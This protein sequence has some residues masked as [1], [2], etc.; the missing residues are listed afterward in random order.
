MDRRDQEFHRAD[1]GG[2]RNARNRKRRKD[3]RQRRDWKRC[4]SNASNTSKPL[5]KTVLRTLT[6][7]NPSRP[8]SPP[9]SRRPDAALTPPQTATGRG[10][11]SP[12]ARSS[13][14]L[15][16]MIGLAAV[17]A[18]VRRRSIWCG[19]AGRGKGG[20]APLDA[21]HHLVFRGN[22]GTGKTT[23]ARIVGRFTRKSG[24]LKSGDMVEAER[25]DLV[26][27]YIGQT[28][29]K[30]KEVIDKAM[31]GVLFIDEAYSLAPPSVAER[32]REGSD[33]DADQGDGGQ[34][35]PAGGDRGRATR[36]E[37][38]HFIDS[39]PGLK[40]RFK[41]YIDFEDY[42][43]EELFRIFLHIGV[44]DTGSGCRSMR[45]R[46]FANLMASLETGK[47]G[48]GNGRTV[49]NIFDEC[50]ARQAA[51]LGDER[52]QGRSHDVREGR[53]SEGRRNG[54]LLADQVKREAKGEQ[55]APGEDACHGHAGGARH[56]PGRPRRPVSSTSGRG[57]ERE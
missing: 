35:R 25:G 43:S 40:S 21:P 56:Q 7:A 48:F 13:A 31:D 49:R 20:N 32:F 30:T 9:R 42:N 46:D 18:E 27:E 57:R 29:P 26:A 24:V 3:I 10:E 33:S 28:A 14:E 52:Q 22:P 38:D 39:N 55:P 53:Y 11:G 44:S 41:T 36:T 5:G 23:V 6:V 54:V 17:K 45:R 12:D 19:W 15:D 16:G 37:M 34:P 51:R 4:S 1:G 2:R 47:K 8:E 50:L